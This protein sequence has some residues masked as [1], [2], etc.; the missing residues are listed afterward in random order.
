LLIKYF[1]L[2]SFVVP[3][4]VNYTVNRPV[5]EKEKNGPVYR[6]NRPVHRGI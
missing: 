5:S 6:W 1:V 2:F 4:R 3:I